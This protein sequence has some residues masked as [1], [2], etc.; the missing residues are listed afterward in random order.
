MLLTNE[1]DLYAGT[2]NGLFVKKKDAT[3]FVIAEDGHNGF[4][5]ALAQTADGK[6]WIGSL[7]RYLRFIDT[8]NAPLKAQ[9]DS[10]FPHRC[11]T[12]LLAT[13]AG[14]LWIGTDSKGVWRRTA[15]GVY[16]KPLLSGERLASSANKLT[17]DADNRL[18]VSTFNGLF[19]MDEQQQ[20]VS[21]YSQ[22]SGL[23]TDF[24]SY[25]SALLMNNTQMFIITDRELG[26]DAVAHHLNMSNS[27]FYR[28]IKT[29]S[30]LSPNEYI[31]LYR[32]K[33]AA[34]M[35]RQEGLSIREVSERLCFSSV[36]YFTNSFSQQFGVTP[37]E[38]V[39]SIPVNNIEITK[40]QKT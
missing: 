11:V 8:Q 3:Q 4:I 27:T 38:Y 17:L 33:K 19:C 5:H 20:S 18:W 13:Q 22:Y 28:R 21:R 10:T 34:L 29:A 14:V 23:P 39:K 25:A 35:L 12:S 9:T 16:H 24:I 26:V 36:A 37:G 40:I 30:G 6:V 7:D 15:D 32:L 1:G 31:R 2:T